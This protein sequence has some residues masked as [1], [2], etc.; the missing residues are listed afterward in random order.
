[1][2]FDPDRSN[3][4][5]V[6]PDR[7]TGV[8]ATAEGMVELGPTKGRALICTARRLVPTVIFAG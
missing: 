2:P 1:M 8:R 7:L 5:P 4:I 3:G 6:E